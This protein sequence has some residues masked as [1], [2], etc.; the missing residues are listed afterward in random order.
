MNKA[1]LYFDK[2]VKEYFM[3]YHEGSSQKQGDAMRK[4]NNFIGM[5]W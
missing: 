4:A 1:E 3:K 5:H 2:E